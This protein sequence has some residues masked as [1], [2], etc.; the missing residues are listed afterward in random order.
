MLLLAIAAAGLPWYLVTQGGD[1]AKPNAQASQTPTTSASPSPSPSPSPT[2]GTYEVF[3]VDRCVNVRAE[4]A[5]S[6]K[7]LD[8]LTVGIQVQ[9]DGRTSEGSGLLWRHIYDPFAKVWGWMAD[10][11]L[12]SV[13]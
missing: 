5:T 9:S 1:D 11:Y 12:R 2:G 3:G 4:P 8:C 10:Q 13:G 6:G 7:W